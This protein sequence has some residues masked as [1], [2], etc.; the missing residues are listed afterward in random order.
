MRSINEHSVPGGWSDGEVKVGLHRFKLLTP[1]NPDELLSHLESPGASSQPHLVDPYWA[2][3]WPA[4]PLLA[5]AVTRSPPPRGTRTL[6]L[7]CGSGLVGIAALAAGLDVTF[8]DYVP[9]AVRLAREN[10]ARNGFLHANGIV[11][12]WRCAA[13]F[14][15]RSFPLILAA[16]VTYDR[17]NLDPLLDVLAL[18]L[19]PGGEAWFGD[20]GRSPAPDFQHRALDRGWS[21]SLFDEH[22]CP[23]TV[24]ALGTYQRFVLRRDKGVSGDVEMLQ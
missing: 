19:A 12:D 15:Y 9:F 24:P 2:K 10:A 23:A 7:G 8:S 13:R 4:A 14:V 17:A 20:A 5:E 6:E 1:A 3:L 11:L 21:V 22:D 16:D 18:A